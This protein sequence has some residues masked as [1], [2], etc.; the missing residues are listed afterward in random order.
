MLGV[1]L[2]A[3]ALDDRKNEDDDDDDEDEEDAAI[4]VEA[5]EDGD[6]N[7]NDDKDDADFSSVGDAKLERSARPA[8]TMA[9][10]KA[11]TRR[12]FSRRR[13]L[14]R[15]VPGKPPD[16]KE[17]EKKVG[18]TIISFRGTH[19]DCCCTSPWVLVTTDN[20]KPRPER[21]SSVW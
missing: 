21:T 17:G 11:K 18:R 14:V 19:D 12:R 9:N 15:P 7:D 4:E 2:R 13:F 5:R 20:G 3:D 8:I 6:D 1:V 16:R 10:A